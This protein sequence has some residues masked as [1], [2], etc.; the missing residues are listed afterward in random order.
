MIPPELAYAVKK[1]SAQDTIHFD[2]ARSLNRQINE[3]ERTQGYAVVSSRPLR[4][5]FDISSVCNA[6][7]IFCLAENGRRSRKDLDAFRPLHWLDNFESLLPFIDFGI[8]SS[9]EA[10][11]NPDFDQFV[12]KLHAY[13]TPFQI[14]TNGKALTPEMSEFI[15]RRG[16]HSIHCSFHS[17]VP[18]TYE[19]IMRGLSFDEVLGNLMHLKLLAR[20]HNP[21]YKLTLVFCAMRRNM[22]QLLDYVDLAHRVGARGIQVNYLMVTTP[23]HKLEKESVFFHQKAYDAYVQAAKIKAAKLGITLDH[24]PLFSAPF[25]AATG[26]CYRP[27]EHL[28]VTREGDVTICCGGAGNLGNIFKDDFFTVWNSKPFR[29]FRRLVNSDTPPAQCRKCTRGKENPR[30]MSTHITYLRSMP[31]NERERRI[32]EL[33]AFYNK[34]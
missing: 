10:M 21:G 26:P 22:E 12:D 28:N 20:K 27:W 14:F 4:L 11:L 5:G 9:Y 18:G 7:C 24:Q 29:V 16:L 34:Q 19:S 1:T 3:F 8:F 2:H 13:A 31:K 33:N 32:E 15:L 30:D 6:N 17:P 25:G 23:K